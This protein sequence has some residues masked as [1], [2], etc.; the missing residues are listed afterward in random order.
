MNSRLYP[1]EEEMMDELED[2][3]LKSTQN[4]IQKQKRHL[5]R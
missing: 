1:R 2:K 5:R 3:F 4:E